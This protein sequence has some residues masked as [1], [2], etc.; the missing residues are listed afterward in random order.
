LHA[1]CGSGQVDTDIAGYVSITGL[2]ISVQALKLFKKTNP[3]CS[4]LHGSIFDI[5]LPAASVD[6]I[7]NL[8]V[9]EHFTEPEIGAILREFFRV[10][11]PR[12]RI[13]IFWPPEFGASVIFLKGVKW[14]LEN[15]LGKQGV[16]IH[17]DE[18]T[19]IQSKASA[20][21]MFEAAGFSVSGYYFGPRDL[22]TYSVIVA[23]KPPE[24]RIA[25]T[26][27]GAPSLET[28]ATLGSSGSQGLESGAPS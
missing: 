16:K 24:A 21:A 25:R 19:R 7:Y 3:G 10:L 13:L 23:E 27:A 22:F 17:P 9:M 18:I 5:P 12:G 4:V 1:G 28:Q 8:G 11:K 20:L 15:V 26:I 14:S 6:G 2:D